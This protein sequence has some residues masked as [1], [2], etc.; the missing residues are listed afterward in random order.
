MLR[1]R[2]LACWRAHVCR[3]RRIDGHEGFLPPSKT[4]E[5]VWYHQ[6]PIKIS[7]MN[8]QGPVFKTSNVYI[9][10]GAG[11]SAHQKH[12]EMVHPAQPHSNFPKLTRTFYALIPQCLF[13]SIEVP[14]VSMASGFE[15][16]SGPRDS[17]NF[18]TEMLSKQGGPILLRVGLVCIG[19]RPHQHGF[20]NDILL[21]RVRLR[22]ISFLRL[23]TFATF[24]T[25]GLLST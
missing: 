13:F 19:H 8:Q 4:T 12:V 15:L 1:K 21:Q 5:V 14:L 10:P 18:V 17:N 9:V 20:A 3:A 16:F 22:V 11:P 23:A 24:H 25:A 2:K 6:S 7:L